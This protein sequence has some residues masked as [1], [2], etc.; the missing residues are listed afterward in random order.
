M[1]LIFALPMIVYIGTIIYIVSLLQRI[2]KAVER[3]A[4]NTE[5]TSAP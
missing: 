2:A 4:V 1:E 3:V 5:R